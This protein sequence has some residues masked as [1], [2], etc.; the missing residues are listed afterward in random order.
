VNCKFKNT[1]L[2]F[3]GEAPIGLEYCTLEKIKLTFGGPAQTTLSLLKNLYTYPV[4]RPLIDN[5]FENIKK[6]KMPVAVP[7]SNVA[8]D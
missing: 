8:K 7:S 2:V 5:T 6:G 1:E 3:R 4:I